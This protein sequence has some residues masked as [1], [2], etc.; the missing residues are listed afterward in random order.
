MEPI[1]VYALLVFVVYLIVTGR[2]GSL[3]SA[4]K[5]AG[6]GLKTSVTGGDNSTPPGLGT[7]NTPQFGGTVVPTSGSSGS[8]NKKTTTGTSSNFNLAQI[9]NNAAAKYGVDPRLVAA[10]IQT[11]SGGNPNA[12]SPAGAE[13]L[14]QLM[15]STANL[16]G[17]AN[18]LDPKQ[19]VD[20]GTRLI[21]NLLKKYKGDKKKAL[22]AYNAGSGAVDKYNG[23]PPYPE[24]QTYVNRIL[25]LLGEG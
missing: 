10:M 1:P 5:S 4:F 8:G 25:K 19:N 24:T 13:G 18:P 6:T 3:W 20:G 22:A 11:E 23:V 21:S 9:I 16:L 2:A 7:E 15:P 12:V 17:V 14:M